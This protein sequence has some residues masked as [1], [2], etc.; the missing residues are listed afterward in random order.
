MS[1]ASR[2]IEGRVVVIVHLRIRGIGLEEHN[3]F[4][5]TVYSGSKY[6]GHRGR[7]DIDGYSEQL[8]LVRIVQMAKETGRRQEVMVPSIVRLQSL[9][10]C[11]GHANSKSEASRLSGVEYDAPTPAI[12]IEL[13][14]DD[15]GISV[16]PRRSFATVEFQVFFGMA[17]FQQ[18]VSELRSDHAVYRTAIL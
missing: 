17:D 7:K 8:M 18:T 1:M 12:G 16:D 6:I 11:L 2:Y 15:I 14:G 13:L 5:A 10:S 9:D 3:G 4:C